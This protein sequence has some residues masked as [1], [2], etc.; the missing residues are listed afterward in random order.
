MHDTQQKK[1]DILSG[2]THVKR[3]EHTR[4]LAI[5]IPGSHVDLGRCAGQ[6]YCFSDNRSQAKQL[7]V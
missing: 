3:T 6:R 2:Q 5:C 7:I 1:L 4:E